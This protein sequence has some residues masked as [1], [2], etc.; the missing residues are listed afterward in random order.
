LA[1]NRRRDP[2]RVWSLRSLVVPGTVSN[3]VRTRSACCASLTYIMRIT[4]P[5]VIQ[6]IDHIRAHTNPAH[7]AGNAGR[8]HSDLAV[9]RRRDPIRVWSLR[10]LVVPGT[11][12]NLVR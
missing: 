6:P 2:I 5:A 7:R 12:S 1:V 8:S 3:L 10:S 4:N 9:N 11:V